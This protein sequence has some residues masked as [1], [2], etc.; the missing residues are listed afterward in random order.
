MQEAVSTPTQAV[1]GKILPAITAAN[2]LGIHAIAS[3]SIA[4]AKNL[5]QLPQNIIHGLGENLKTDAVR[6]LQFTRSVPGLSSALVGMKSP[7]H[8]AENLALTSIPPLDA[9]DFDQ[10][11]VRE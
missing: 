8:V 2:Q 4:Q 9:A 5:V 6:A 10:L 3:A 1:D 11:G 7:N